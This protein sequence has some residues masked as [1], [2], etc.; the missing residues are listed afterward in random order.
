VDPHHLDLDPDSTFHPDADPDSNFYLIRMRVQNFLIYA[1][2]DPDP[3]FHPEADPDSDPDPGF[4]IK[5]QTIHFG[6]SSAN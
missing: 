2:A 3:T 6:L 5:A 4:Q 1:D